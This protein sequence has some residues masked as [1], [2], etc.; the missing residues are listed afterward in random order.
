M[1]EFHSHPYFLTP[2]RLNPGYPLFVFLPGMDES[3]SLA[4]L[5]TTTVETGFD[6]RT[7]DST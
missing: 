5:Q 6:V 3:T 1:S 7:C 4:H 2:R